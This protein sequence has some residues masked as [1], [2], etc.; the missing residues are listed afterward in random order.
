MRRAR[1]QSARTRGGEVLGL[2][3]LP[4]RWLRAPACLCRPHLCWRRRRTPPH[5]RPRADLEQFESRAAV[6][7]ASLDQARANLAQAEL[8]LERTVVRAPFDGRV[9]ERRVDLGQ[10]VSP[11]V[12][13]ARIFSV[14]YAEV[15]L[16]IRTEDLS[17]VEVP[18]G[19]GAEDLSALDVPVTL[20]A[21][22]GGEQREWL[23]RNPQC[24]WQPIKRVRVGAYKFLLELDNAIRVATGLPGLGAFIIELVVL[25]VG[26]HPER[27]P[28][29]TV[30]AD[31]GSDGTAATAYLKRQLKHNL[32]TVSDESHDL[33]NDI[34]TALK[35]S[36]LGDHNTLSL[37]EK[38]RALYSS[39]TDGGGV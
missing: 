34:E 20:S 22:L 25:E 6:A 1:V 33:N 17:Y 38:K 12:S 2:R 7:Q 15:R 26:R 31:R 16:P 28:R 13:L 30:A 3:R 19:L 35:R 10:F 14:D 23:A 18:L 4:L 21:S 36:G 8:D 37:V 29:L 27:W 5:L 9:R 11:G 39:S 32:E 24:A